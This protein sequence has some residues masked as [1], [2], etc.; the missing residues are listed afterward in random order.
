MAHGRRDFFKRNRVSR[1]GGLAA[2]ARLRKNGKEIKVVI[3]DYRLP[4]MD[5]ID[6]AQTMRHELNLW[7]SKIIMLSSWEGMNQKVQEELKIAHTIKKPILQ[8][9]LFEIFLQELR[10]DRVEPTV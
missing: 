8:S 4:E 10:V 9:K 2:I 1:T 6:V 7:D 3:L 5:G